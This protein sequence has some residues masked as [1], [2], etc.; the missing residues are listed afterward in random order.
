MLALFLH[1][2]CPHNFHLKPGLYMKASSTDPPLCSFIARQHCTHPRSLSW[3][4]RASAPVTPIWGFT[5]CMGQAQKDG[6][7]V[8]VP[9]ARFSTRMPSFNIVCT[10]PGCGPCTDDT[11][12][13][14]S[15]WLKNASV[16]DDRYSRLSPPRSPNPREGNNLWNC[17]KFTVNIAWSFRGIFF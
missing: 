1:V 13:G 15:H 5:A 9:D 10:D 7:W 2:C 3:I 16:C 12:S 4:F 11:M 17:F 6:E 8:E 14:R